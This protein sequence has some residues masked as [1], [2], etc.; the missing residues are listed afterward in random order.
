MNLPL[1]ILHAPIDEPVVSVDGAWNA[2]GLNL[3]HWPGNTT[4]AE[5]KHDLSTGIALNFARLPENRRETLARGCDAIANNH[6][7]T[8]GACAVFAVR[9]PELALPRAQALLDIAESGDFFRFPSERAF[10]INMIVGNL[11][12][13]Q[14]SPWRERFDGFDERARHEFVLMEIVE[15]FTEILDGDL[16]PY[17]DLWQPELEAVS[18]DRTD[19]AAAQKDEITHLDL[20]VWTASSNARSTRSRERS[21]HFDP[22]RHALFGSTRADRVLAIGPKKSGATYRLLLSTLSWFDIVSRRLQPRPDMAALAARLNALEDA[23]PAGLNAWR[24]EE[25][26]TPSPELWFGRAEQE[27][28]G[29]HALVLEE[30]RLEPPVVRLAIADAL[31]ACWVFPECPECP[32]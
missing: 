21:S 23:D 12:D 7:D 22:G 5:L 27:M 30:S 3:S 28:F 13:E 11:A 31:R 6:F 8:E 24:F 29:E 15:H 25:E 17:A 1:R 20:C 16:A 4:P 14:R 9:H 10:Q 18:S 32:E 19:L 2:P 26:S